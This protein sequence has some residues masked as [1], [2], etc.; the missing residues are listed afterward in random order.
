LK[1][2]KLDTARAAS[3]LGWAPKVALDDGVARTVEFFREV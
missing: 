1:R 2:S 3:V